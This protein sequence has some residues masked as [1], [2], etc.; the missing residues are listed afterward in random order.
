MLDV[1][2]RA[3]QLMLPALIGDTYLGSSYLTRQPQPRP[4]LERELLAMSIVLRDGT[5]G[6]A[7]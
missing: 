7:P 1:G 3:P 4:F 5:R 2:S 6:E